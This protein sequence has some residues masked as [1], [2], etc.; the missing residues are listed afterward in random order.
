ME[1]IIFLVLAFLGYMW[2]RKHEAQ[3]KERLEL[4]LF[5]H[6]RWFTDHMG[7]DWD[8]DFVDMSLTVARSTTKRTRRSKRCRL[9]TPFGAKRVAAGNVR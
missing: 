1:W 4:R 3:K 7:Q 5:S 6:R 8:L 9:S 2:A